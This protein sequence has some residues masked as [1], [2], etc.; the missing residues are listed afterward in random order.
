MHKLLKPIIRVSERLRRRKTQT[1]PQR[2]QFYRTPETHYI[3]KNKGISQITIC[4]IT[5]KIFPAYKRNRRILIPNLFRR[6]SIHSSYHC[7]SNNCLNRSGRVNIH[8]SA[9]HSSV[10][11][12]STQLNFLFAPYNAGRIFRLNAH[13][14]VVPKQI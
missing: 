1:V 8:A 5:K 11:K 3:P 13:N 14:K 4:I 9:S 10:R 7:I 2:I 6:N 12:L